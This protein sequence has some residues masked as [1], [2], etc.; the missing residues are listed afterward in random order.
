MADLRGRALGDLERMSIDRGRIIGIE[1]VGRRSR[2]IVVSCDGE[3]E[4]IAEGKPLGML[5]SQPEDWPLR[6][7]ELLEDVADQEALGIDELLD[8]TKGLVLALSCSRFPYERQVAIPEAL[9]AAGLKFPDVLVVTDAE[10]LYAANIPGDCGAAVVLDETSLVFARNA[11]DSRF[12]GGWGPI[13]GAACGSYH[14]GRT[15]LAAVAES[16]DGLGPD[17][18]VLWHE[19]NK[20]LEED[21]SWLHLCS[22]V[23]SAERRTLV[24]TFLNGLM[25]T[26]SRWRSLVSRLAKGVFAAWRLGDGTADDIVQDIIVAS[27]SRVERLSAALSLDVT[28]IPIVVFGELLEEEP[29]LAAHL[30]TQLTAN[31]DCFVAPS[32]TDCICLGPASGAV[33]LGLARHG[34]PSLAETEGTLLEVLRS[35]SD[36]WDL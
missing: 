22:V 36:Q 15:A 12:A 2:A 3:I 1:G 10:A 34:V 24:P 26:S 30:R 25:N 4:G 23:P 19:L 17:C 5:R 32:S 7:F 6:I 8:H 35:Q 9:G 16:A 11:V 13:I 27:C 14:C 31:P 20:V 18:D 28:Q 29:Q 21:P 33:A